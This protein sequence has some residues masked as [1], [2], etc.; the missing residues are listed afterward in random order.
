MAEDHDR[1]IDRWIRATSPRLV[2]ALT[3][4]TGDAGLAED[5]AQEAFARA[6]E[7]WHDVS[8][9]ANP[10]GWVYRVA[11]NLATSGGRR[12]SAEQRAR[13]RIRRSAATDCR[14]GSSMAAGV[15]DRITL[16]DALERLS[17]RQRAAVVL[18]FY[19]Q[20]SVAE[21]ADVMGCAPGTVKALTSQGVAAL[22]TDLGVTLGLGVIDG[23]GALIEEPEVDH[24]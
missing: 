8:Q 16:R 7:Q 1:D 9:M 19:G 18:R 14:R 17:D 3:L 6:W 13:H 4:H 10:G 15:A 21:A 20:L 24:A 2:G 12:R 11:F 5:V 22:R 23:A